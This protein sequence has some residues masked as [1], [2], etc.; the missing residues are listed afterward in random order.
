MLA[1]WSL[2]CSNLVALQP[3]TT[4]YGFPHTP[5]I[6]TKEQTDKW[7]PIVAAVKKHNAIFFCQLW[8]VGRQSHHGEG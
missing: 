6:H 4:G 5:G 8:H 2:F 7:K 1:P 3:S